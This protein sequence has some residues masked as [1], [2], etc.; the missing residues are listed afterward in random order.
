MQKSRET[1][2]YSSITALCLCVLIT[3]IVCY[4]YFLNMS[5]VQV[6]LRTEHVQA[7]RTL[8]ADIAM[9]ESQ[10]IEAQ[11]TVSARIGELDGYNIDMAKIFVSREAAS[12][13]MRDQ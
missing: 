10:Y 11:H 5:V 8:H 13:V 3:T 2:T 7:Q 4:L 12:L 9:L 1:I 6:V